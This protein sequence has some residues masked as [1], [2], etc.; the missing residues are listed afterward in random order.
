[1]AFNTPT[2]W[3]SKFVKDLRNYAS[4]DFTVST[5][6]RKTCYIEIDDYKETNVKGTLDL[7]FLIKGVYD[8]PEHYVFAHT[9]ETMRIC[10]GDPRLLVLYMYVLG[11]LPDESY[12]MLYEYFKEYLVPE[13]GFGN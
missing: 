5:M 9:D 3:E 12:A 10:M 1:M 8:S 7:I 6:P 11:G 2:S 4:Q 13:F